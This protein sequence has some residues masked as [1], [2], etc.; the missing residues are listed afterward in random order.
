MK[1][2]LHVIGLPH[3]ASTKKEFLHCGYTQKMRSFCQMMHEAGHTVFHYGGEGS[4]APCAE[5]I[6][7]LTKAEREQYFHSN[8]EAGEFPDMEF[9]ANL[10]YWMVMNARA[11]RAIHDRI[12]PLD[13][14]C[15]I[16]GLSQGPITN[17][18]PNNPSIEYGVG[19][20]GVTA[21][22]RCFESHAWRHHV[23]GLRNERN[24][25]WYDTVIGN[26]YDPADFPLGERKGDYYLFLGRLILRKNPH[27]AVDVCKRIGAKLIIAG[28]GVT[29]R[30]PGIVRSR[31]L[32]IFGD[33]VEH[34]GVADAKKRAELLGNAKALFVLTQYLAPFEGV[35][36]EANLCGCPVITTDWG[37]FPET[38]VNGLNGYRIHTIGEAMWAARN[39]HKLDPRAI[40]E[41]ALGKFTLAVNAPKY[42]EWID[43]VVAIFKGP[44]QSWYD[45]SPGALGAQFG[46][47]QHPRLVAVK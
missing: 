35:H 10:P 19:Y 6:T 21:K 42:E 4:D 2:R 46:E 13:V 33:H 31:E 8:W 36:A 27:V 1:H 3:T 7:L 44:G 22:F 12:R 16:A 45:E 25:S 24:G 37:V 28:Q 23:Y 32:G 29:M 5:H 30:E 18:F 11:I 34:I 41:Y 15:M 14:L 9:N 40:R 38:V 20:E 43:R 17:A 26:Y 39:V 47:T